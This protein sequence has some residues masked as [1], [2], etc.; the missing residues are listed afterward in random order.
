M[1][2]PSTFQDGGC[3]CGAVR[4]RLTGPF[5]YS[6][7]C[8]CRSCQKALGAGYATFSA[9]TPEN[10]EIIKGDMAVY[11]SSPGV[12]RGFCK[13]CG[14]SLSYWGDAWTDYAILSATLDDPA[15]ATPTRNVF[16]SHKQP[17]IALDETLKESP[18]FP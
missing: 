15:T 14:T 2:E 5:T 7:H 1:A 18:E 13:T 11:N 12:Y 17:W 8:H 16:T 9:V 3:M 10:F 4:Y 6:A